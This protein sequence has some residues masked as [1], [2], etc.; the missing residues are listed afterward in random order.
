M[1][2]CITGGLG[3]LGSH[4]AV[5]LISQNHSVILI[6]N[7]SNSEQNTFN[8][9]SNL[10]NNK[11]NTNIINFYNLDIRRKDLLEK[12]FK[13]YNFDVIINTA[14]VKNVN[15]V[16]ELYRIN[17]NIV[18]NLLDMVSMFKIKQFIHFSSWIVYG[19]KLTIDFRFNEKQE[20]FNRNIPN[21]YGKS[22]LIQEEIINDFSSSHPNTK[23]YILRKFEVGGYHPSGILGKDYKLFSFNVFH[24]L[25]IT[26]VGKKELSIFGNNYSTKDGT[27]ARDYMNIMDL[28]LIVSKLLNFNEKKNFE[29]FNLGNNKKSTIFQILKSFNTLSDF[30]IEYN[31]KNGCD[32][33]I[34]IVVSN[35]SK[36]KEKLIYTSQFSINDSIISL[37]TFYK[38]NYNKHSL[39]K[40]LQKLGVESYQYYCKE[41]VKFIEEKQPVEKLEVKPKINEN[42]NE[43]LV[44]SG[45]KAEIESSEDSESI[46]SRNFIETKELNIS[47]NTKIDEETEQQKEDFENL[48]VEKE[49][50][51]ENKCL[52]EEVLIDENT[53]KLEIIENNDKSEEEIENLQNINDI[54]DNE[55]DY[56]V[57]LQIDEK[58][59]I[60]TEEIENS[61][62]IQQDDENNYKQ[63]DESEH[64]QQSNIKDDDDESDQEEYKSKQEEQ[65][66]TLENSESDQ[67]EIKDISNVTESE[68]ESENQTVNEDKL[69]N[70]CEFK[71]NYIEQ[72]DVPNNSNYN[73]FSFL[74]D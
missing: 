5:E 30:K 7:L 9:I 10:I 59:K 65:Q 72:N 29:I 12:V 70:N 69:I 23:F 37:E 32:F 13:K 6:D 14:E 55:I 63:E 42:N 41:G 1:F 46:S 73:Y 17:L 28:A 18:N 47:N 34:P 66:K 19:E 44:D 57:F 54:S 27:F 16:T 20:I 31:I 45:Y 56:N 25:L 51:E 38:Q 4:I 22:K 61:N 58:F 74:E 39:Y 43:I 2:I 40:S 15:S 8:N 3:Y 49:I 26:L 24:Y 50:L 53:E 62:E 71:E 68:S 21:T 11:L 48:P 33:D 64:D 36:L 60:N 52:N 67:E 35:S